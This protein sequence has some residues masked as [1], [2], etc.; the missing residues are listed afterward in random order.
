MVADFGSIGWNYLDQQLGLANNPSSCLCRKPEHHKLWAHMSAGS[1]TGVFNASEGV[2]RVRK[3]FQ[4]PDGTVV[5]FA[6]ITEGSTA[7]Y[8]VNTHP[9]DLFSVPLKMEPRGYALAAK[10]NWSLTTSVNNAILKMRSNGQLESLRRK[11]WS[12]T[13]SGGIRQRGFG[14]LVLSS[15]ATLSLLMTSSLSSASV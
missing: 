13:C 1:G 15:I 12:G 14:A 11:W 10:K 9:C 6:F 8:Y 5:P 3:G 4:K 7:E 2:E